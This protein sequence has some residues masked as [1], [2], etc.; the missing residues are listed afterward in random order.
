M[1]RWIDN[2]HYA[3]IKRWI[4]TSHYTDLKRRSAEVPDDDR[5]AEVPTVI[6]PSEESGITQAK[7]TWCYTTRCHVTSTFKALVA[8][9]H[10]CVRSSEAHARVTATKKWVDPLNYGLERK[11]SAYAQFSKCF[12]QNCSL[13]E[14][15]D[16]KA[17][18]RRLCLPQLVNDDENQIEAL[19]HV[20]GN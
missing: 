18:V 14:R 6:Q 20:F 2:S 5:S 13:L 17:C 15:E 4:D 9:I 1:K 16:F 11:R 10:S 7:I 12:H 8:C 19:D 3:D